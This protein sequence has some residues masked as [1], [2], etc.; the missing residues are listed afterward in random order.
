[1]NLSSD[2]GGP[3]HV[4]SPHGLRYCLLVID[5]Q[6]N[7]LRVRFLRSK[8]DTCPHVEFIIL[9]ICHVHE[10][11]HSSSGAFALDLKFDSDHVFEATTTRLCVVG[12][13]SVSN[14][15]PRVLITCS[16]RPNAL[17]TH[18][19]TMPLRCRMTCPF[20]TPCARARS[21][22]L[23]TFATVRLAARL[24]YPVAFPSPSSHRMS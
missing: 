13:V 21:A 2:I 9:E 5:H 11:H 4:P 15:L 22:L 10:Q 1:M 8:D 19:K 14:T 18:S 6:A 16:A 3:V 17:G 20:R 7:Y 12:W 23:C 24:E